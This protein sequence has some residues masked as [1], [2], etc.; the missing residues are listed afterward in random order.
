[1]VASM[2]IYNN[3]ETRQSQAQMIEAR[4]AEEKQQYEA[5]LEKW[6]KNYPTDHRLLIARRLQKFLAVSV[7][8]DFN[9]QLVE[10][11]GYMKFA[12]EQYEKK[13]AEWKLCFRAGKETVD[14]ARAFATAWLATLPQN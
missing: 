3:P 7:D 2:E 13:S 11:D 8:V 6:E 5:E 4:R 10:I 12:D 1:M 14:A 9:A